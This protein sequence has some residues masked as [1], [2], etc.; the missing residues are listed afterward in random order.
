MRSLSLLKTTITPVSAAF[1]LAFTGC[2][3]FGATPLQG[4]GQ[5]DPSAPPTVT[6]TI[7]EQGASNVPLSTPLTITFSRPMVTDSLEII[8]EPDLALPDPVWDEAGTEV[9]FALVD[10]PVNVEFV[11][12]LR[13]FATNNRDLDFSLTFRTSDPNDG[14][15]PTVLSTYPT[16]GQSNV[17]TNTAVLI[18]FSEPMQTTAPASA[19]QI[20]PQGGSPIGC[21]LTW[22]A[23]DAQVVCD[24]TAALAP[25][26]LHTI[27]IAAGLSDK[28][29][30]PLAP[31]SIAFTTGAGSDTSAPTLVD[32]RYDLLAERAT[33]TTYPL[34]QNGLARSTNIIFEFSEPMKGVDLPDAMLIETKPPGLAKSKLAGTFSSSNGGR[35]WTFNPTGSLSDGALITWATTSMVVDLADQPVTPV[36]GLRRGLV[37]GRTSVTYT[38]D[39]NDW[40]YTSS[41]TSTTNI[42]TST[43]AGRSSGST[44]VALMSF[45]TSLTNPLNVVSARLN[46]V[47]M[48]V[49]PEDSGSPYENAQIYAETVD[50][51]VS[52]TAGDYDTPVLENCGYT[53]CEP[54]DFAA[55]LRTMISNNGRLEQKSASVTGSIVRSIAY[56]RPRVQFRLKFNAVRSSTSAYAVF[57]GPTH[58]TRANR[59]T[60]QITYE[61]LLSFP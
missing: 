24:P 3:D 16:D 43:R 61:H 54:G 33:P 19:L 37:V 44:I 25:S 50:Y 34:D 5:L 21:A 55:V 26:K 60:L 2:I 57:T 6:A 9:S 32:V 49:F 58:A 7:P 13:A 42:T 51:G 17:P 10:L 4:N 36:S 23:A 22:Q 45:D 41:T 30:N 40:G 1:A 27:T 15:V 46:V 59:P 20:T 56:N 53:Q 11:V 31:S 35:T 38:A 18:T 48:F 14:Q 12:G 47:Q 8:V 28:K 39:S 29:G 52:L